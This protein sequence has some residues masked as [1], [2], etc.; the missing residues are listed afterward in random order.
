MIFVVVGYCSGLVSKDH[1]VPLELLPG[2]KDDYDL[3]EVLIHAFPRPLDSEIRGNHK[4]RKK[5]YSMNYELFKYVGN[6]ENNISRYSLPYFPLCDLFY[7][8]TDQ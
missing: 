5:Y 6:L 3:I 7:Y 4:L 8:E 2:S 1:E